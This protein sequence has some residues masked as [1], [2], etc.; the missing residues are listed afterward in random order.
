ME[1]HG[2]ILTEISEW[3]PAEIVEESFERRQI[4]GESLDECLVQRGFT[5]G[6][7][8]GIPDSIPRLISTGIPHVTPGTI[9]PVRENSERAGTPRGIPAKIPKGIT[10]EILESFLK[11]VE[12]YN[13][14][15][16]KNHR[17]NLQ[18]IPWTLFFE[19][20]YLNF[21]QKFLDEFL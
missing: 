4:R 15:F 11:N 21:Q 8:G 14:I 6:I 10:I 19:E 18:N 7:F 9:Y 2:V 17:R 3:I 5:G 13:R 1:I 12:K 16:G 20:L